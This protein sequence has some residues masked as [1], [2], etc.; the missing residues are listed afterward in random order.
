MARLNQN[1]D[2]LTFHQGWYGICAETEEECADF[3]LIN[4][5]G[6]TSTKLYS[7]I[8]AIFEVRSDSFGQLSYNGNI[9]DGAT[10]EY[11]QIRSLK[12]GHSYLIILK[13]GDG[14]L[15][16]EN[17]VPANSESTDYRMVSSCEVEDDPTPTPN[18]I[19]SLTN[20]S[21]SGK[22]LQFRWLKRGDKEILQVLNLHTP[23]NYIDPDPYGQGF[24][25]PKNIE[26]RWLTLYLKTDDAEFDR[27][28][29]QLQALAKY[30][31]TAI[32]PFNYFDKHNHIQFDGISFSAS[33]IKEYTHYP[34]SLPFSSLYGSYLKIDDEYASVYTC[35]RI[36]LRFL[37][38]FKS[39]VFG[40]R[41]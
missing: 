28:S 25:Y 8:H 26:D 30:F 38:T 39:I 17:F 14:Y 33:N 9:A 20:A 2:N 40:S 22:E 12:C 19:E 23:Y 27:D 11:Q 31:P 4:G 5:E 41:R 29:K 16:V 10:L 24:P 18:Q 3:N 1:S 35:K 13:K 37:F 21:E 6:V 34:N 36:E 32:I 15:E 7:Q